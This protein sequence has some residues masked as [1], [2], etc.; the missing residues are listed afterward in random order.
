MLKMRLQ[1]VGRKHEPSFRLVLTDS[2]N[3]TKSGRF[4]EILGSY[5]P[6]KSTDLFKVERIKHWLSH[7]VQPTGS[8]HNL[9]VTH[10]IIEGKKI[11]VLP[12]KTPIIKV[13]P[14]VEN[15]IET[16]KEEESVTAKAP[17]IIAE[18]KSE[19]VLAETAPS[20]I[21]EPET[22]NEPSVEAPPEVI[23]VEISEEIK[24]EE[25]TEEEVKKEDSAV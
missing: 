11:N 10:K 7:G 21:K 17:E 13:E 1:R 24:P 20:E 12:K 16:P 18:E 19:E 23:P 14:V 22:V 8:V 6:R 15:K 3:S 2:K 4:K 25:P 9:L 5:D